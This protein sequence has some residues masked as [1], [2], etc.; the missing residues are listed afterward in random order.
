MSVTVVFG[1]AGSGKT[2]LCLKEMQAWTAQGGKAIMIVPDQAT[3]TMERRFASSMPG[4]GFMGTQIFG[5]SRLAFRVLQERGK[6]HASLSE[7]SRSIILQRLLRK[8]GPELTVLQTAARQPNFVSS[9]GQFLMECRSFRVTPETLRQAAHSL[10][11]LTL[12]HK[13]DDMAQLYDQYLAFLSDHFGDAD[14]TLTLL[15]EE[16][17]DYSFIQGARVWVDG[18]QWFTPEQLH[19]L[20]VAEQAAAS[21]TVTLTMDAQQLA[22]QKRH[23]ALFH[24]PWE[25]YQSLLQTFPHIKTQSL[26]TQEVKEIRRFTEGFFQP[27]PRAQ[28]EPVRELIVSECAD[29]T[30]E[31]DA[32]ARRITRLVQHGYRYRDFLVLTRKS[33]RYDAIGERIFSNYGIP[34]FTDYRRPMTSHPAAEAVAALLA[35]L[36]SHWTHE[37]VFRL[38]K[39]DLFPLPREDVDI[40]ENY[41]LANG[42]SS[43]HWLSNRDWAFYRRTYIGD[44]RSDDPVTQEKLQR[45]NGI[46]CRVRKLILPYWQDAQEKKS[47]CD[48]CTLLY[49]ALKSLGVPEQLRRWQ[50][51][52][53]AAGHSLE[54]VEHEQVWKKLLAFLEEITTLCGDDEADL[55]EFSQMVTDGLETMTFSII[56]PTLDHVTL[57]SIERGYTM[58]ARIVFICGLNDGV[59]P[60]HSSEEGLLN[61]AERQTLQEAGITLGPGSRFRSLQEKFLFYLASTRARERLY[62]SYA[63]ADDTGEALTP[64]LWLR[65]MKDKGY[66]V[67]ARRET[68]DVQDENVKDYLVS[69]PE[70]LKYLPARLRP[71]VE[72]QPVAPVWWALYDWALEH[73]L[74]EAARRAVSGLFYSNRPVFLPQP[75][76]RSLY[77][78]RGRLIGSVT[79]FENYRQCPFAYF[80]QYGLKLEERPVQRF[81][82]PDLGMLLHEALRRIG[83]QL[84]QDGR[85]WQHLGEEE[86]PALCTQIVDTLSPRIQND[87]LLSNAYFIQ[88]RGRLIQVLIRT[89]KRLRDFN[90]A[91]DFHT[92]VVEKGF[93]RGPQAWKPLRFTLKNGLEVLVTGQIDRIDTLRADDTDFVVVIDYKSGSTALDLGK[94]YTGLELQLL[95]YMAVAL[96]NL[97]PQ[98]APAAVL[99]C[100]VRNR[101]LSADHLPASEEKAALYNKENKMRGFYLDAPDIMQLLDTSMEADSAF[102]NLRLKKDGSLSTQSKSVFPYTW[103]QHAISLAEN[104]IRDIA[105]QMGSGDISIHPVLYDGRSHCQFCPYR[106]LCAFD[107]RAGENTY[108]VPEALKNDEIIA[109]ISQEGG[110]SHDLD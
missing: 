67:A 21:L 82:A 65:Q 2:A 71:A 36:C 97:G 83:E 103:W 84:L 1:K 28:E 53:E 29:C 72:E 101:R 89:V 11:G 42:I 25:V 93:G 69:L 14:D 19:V 105:E 4:H 57:T 106:A 23:T 75:V 94:I 63:L 26:P 8:Y 91:S 5:F 18:F 95:T 61:D 74:K 70:A 44:D 40:L 86:I 3:Y 45:I 13:V 76:V 48:W 34:C 20:E 92:V 7:L 98:A 22:R 60:Q 46:R 27:V 33:D 15:A 87:I 68:G 100:Y 52:D 47:L 35:M 37:T 31:I 17:P 30:A 32:I 108:D 96:S 24:R 109:R 38:L 99:Y 41:C 59:F 49:T 79:R 12:S 58:Q 110:D 107:P 54:S 73:G 85:Q 102:L 43:R 9:L 10:T 55:R 104:R 56:P 51:E 50:A 66:Y 64:A 81:A 78:P 6:D 16:L 39:T 88:I 90:A 62:L 80:S 77:A